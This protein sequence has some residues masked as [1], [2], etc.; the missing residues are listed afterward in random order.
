MKEEKYSN[1][2]GVTKHCLTE[3][4]TI[5]GSSICSQVGLT[6]QHEALKHKSTKEKGF[7]LCKWP[8]P[9]SHERPAERRT[10]A[11]SDFNGVTPSKWKFPPTCSLPTENG[12]Q[13]RPSIKTAMEV[14][15][16]S[17]TLRL[18]NRVKIH[19]DQIFTGSGRS[20]W[21]SLSPISEL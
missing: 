12:H 5:S 18:K 17:N 1:K 2:L 9:G 10:S 13:Q 3:C 7:S 20:N 11:E 19:W 6:S 4:N 21:G 15:C 8:S 16:T 14:K